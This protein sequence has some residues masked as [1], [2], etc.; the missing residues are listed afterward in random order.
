MRTIGRVSFFA[1]EKAMKI[2]AALALLAIAIPAHAKP[3]KPPISGI[4]SDIHQSQASGDLYGYE[5]R[6]MKFSDRDY[7]VIVIE[8]DEAPE[9]ARIELTGHHIAF[10]AAGQTWAGEVTAKGIDFKCPSGVDSNCVQAHL[11]RAPSFWKQD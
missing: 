8:E 2:V 5:L 1:G 4:Y 6:I 11:P 9:I 3:A 10:K 7:Y